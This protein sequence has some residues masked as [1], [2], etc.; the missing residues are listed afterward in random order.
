MPHRPQPNSPSTGRPGTGGRR[1]RALAIAACLIFGVPVIASAATTFFQPAATPVELR[2]GSAGLAPDPATTPEAVVQVYAARTRG[3]R[4][5]F[6]DHTWIAFKPEGAK[7][8]TRYEVV[9][10]GVRERGTSVRSGG[11]PDGYWA[12]NRPELVFDRR[13]EGVEAMTARIEEAVASYP[14]ADRYLAWPGPN[15]N[16]FIAHIARSVPELGIALPSTA[17]GKDFL[18]DGGVFARAPSGTG[19]QAS[20]FGLIGVMASGEEGLEINLLGLSFGFDFRNP[21]LKLP[22]LGRIGM[23]ARG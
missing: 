12:G 14:Y 9:G 6:A 15:S 18:T 23:A 5:I 19:Y 16:T 11:P 21:A 13:G 8:F 4:G 17:I 7:S 1:G 2:W 3:W 20:L 10:F 22:G